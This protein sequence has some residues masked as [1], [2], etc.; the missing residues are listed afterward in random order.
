MKPTRLMTSKDRRRHPFDRTARKSHRSPITDYCYHPVAFGES[1]GHYT[2]YPSRSVWTIAGDYL[3][4]EARH[5]FQS[6]GIF[7]AAL[8]ISRALPLI[9]NVTALIGIVGA[10]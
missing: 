9:G 8:T 3:K 6:E 10:L 5:D 4:D 1:S 2:R 7:F